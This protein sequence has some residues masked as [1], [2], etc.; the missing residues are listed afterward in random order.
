MP[1]IVTGSIATDY[2]MKYPGH[3]REHIH[4][5]QGKISLSFLVE[6][7]AM[8]R[9]GCGPNIAYSLALLGQPHRLM[10]TAG[11]DFG[12]Y[13]AWL[14]S[15]GVDTAQQLTFAMDLSPLVQNEKL[16]IVEYVVQF[17]RTFE[18]DVRRKISARLGA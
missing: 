1:V 18:A 12:D 6:E 15:H 11:Q 17:I 3:I 7:K 9:G 4:M 14:E 8:S 5:E 13:K 10:G 2:L 16:D